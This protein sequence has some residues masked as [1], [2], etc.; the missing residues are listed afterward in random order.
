MIPDIACVIFGVLGWLAAGWFYLHL[1]RW[2]RQCQHA[3]I[4]IAY[5]QKVKLEAPL[6][7]W[8]AWVKMVDKDKQSHGRVVYRLGGTSVAIVG[9]VVPPNRLQ[10]WWRKTVKRKQQPAGPPR[11][12]VETTSKT[13]ETVSA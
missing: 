5:K 4:A 3:R 1:W 13:R 10:S 11:K 6:V 9:A 7:E 12:T 8:L 2:A